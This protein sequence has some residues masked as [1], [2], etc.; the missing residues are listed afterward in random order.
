MMRGMSW[1]PNRGS[2]MVFLP[3]RK[4]ESRLLFVLVA[5]LAMAIHPALGAV[6]D[7]GVYCLYPRDG[8]HYTFVQRRRPD[9]DL[10]FYLSLWEGGGQFMG[11][12]G[13]AHKTGA[14]RWTYAD[15]MDA[16]VFG[17]RCKVAFVSTP[18]GSF[19]IRGDQQY[20]CNNEG[21]AG[22]SVG[23]IEFPAASYSAPVT[24]QLEHREE[25]DQPCDQR[26]QDRPKQR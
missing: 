19:H 26:K 5:S 22:A 9:G 15:N 13:T 11:I 8:G 2:A 12:A 7:N 18:A 24:D 20:T 23:V 4:T 6:R 14:R 10:D 1:L 3:R 16:E 25:G 17:D 21:G